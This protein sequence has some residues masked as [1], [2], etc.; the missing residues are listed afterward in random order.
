MPTRWGDLFGKGLAV[1]ADLTIGH[2]PT[3]GAGE[4]DTSYV[5]VEFDDGDLHVRC[6]VNYASLLVNGRYREGGIMWSV[7]DS[8]R[9]V[10]LIGQ[11][12][13]ARLILLAE[14]SR[15]GDG[16]SCEYPLVE[17]H[18]VHASRTQL[19]SGLLRR[20]AEREWLGEE[21]RW[22]VL[23]RKAME[24]FDIDATLRGL[25]YESI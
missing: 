9:E 16:V 1:M 2:L 14:D 21:E 19:F 24:A 11:E 25:G 20:L 10:R 4:F 17:D 23:V 7:T 12:G 22:E 5:P 18:Y 3:I 6:M 13:D 8:E 15:T